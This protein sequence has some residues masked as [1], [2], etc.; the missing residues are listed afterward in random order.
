MTE[1]REL[2]GGGYR[3][4]AGVCRVKRKGRVVFADLPTFRLVGLPTCWKVGEL[5]GC[6]GKERGECRGAGRLGRVTGSGGA[7][8][9]GAGCGGVRSGGE[10]RGGSVYRRGHGGKCGVGGVQGV[11]CCD[12]L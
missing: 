5:A 10:C 8:A 12:E 1:R 7:A 4:A 9:G 6:G 2:G 11:C 3:Q